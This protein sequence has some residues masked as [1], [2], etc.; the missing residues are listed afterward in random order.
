MMDKLMYESDASRRDMIISDIYYLCGYIVECSV[1]YAIYD[2]ISYSRTENV[3]NLNTTHPNNVEKVAFRDD[4]RLP[5]PKYTI[6]G[7]AFYTNINVLGAGSGFIQRSG[8]DYA[9]IPII[10]SVSVSETA[11]NLFDSWDPA[12]RYVP[13]IGLNEA[14]VKEFFDVCSAIRTGIHTKIAP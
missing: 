10:G 7:H 12:Y 9:S 1:N 8:A 6:A 14:N 11:R 4:K 5:R 13:Q 3:K 2:L